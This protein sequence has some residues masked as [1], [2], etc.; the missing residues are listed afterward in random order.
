MINE[1]NRNFLYYIQVYDIS[2]IMRARV[3]IE[4]NG[5]IRG[6]ITDFEK[7]MQWFDFI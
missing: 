7:L 5:Q 3:I 4:S 2:G 6:F 1:S